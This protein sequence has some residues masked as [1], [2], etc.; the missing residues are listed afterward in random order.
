MA[1][2]LKNLKNNSG[3]N[4]FVKVKKQPTKVFYKREV[5]KNSKNSQENTCVAVFVK[6][7]LQASVLQLY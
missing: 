7:K 4:Q 2:Y 1:K 3:G 5:L 6:I